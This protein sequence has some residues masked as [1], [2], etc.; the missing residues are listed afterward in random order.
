MALVDVYDS[1][2]FSYVFKKCQTII[3]ETQILQFTNKCFKKY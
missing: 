1:G 3:E 2:S